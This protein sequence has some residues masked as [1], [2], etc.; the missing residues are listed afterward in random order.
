MEKSVRQD[1]SRPSV[2]DRKLKPA[3]G[4]DSSVS[5]NGVSDA[6]SRDPSPTPPI[7]REIQD[8]GEYVSVKLPEMDISRKVELE[9]EN[10]R[11]RKELAE[12]DAEIR[13]KQDVEK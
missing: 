9:A 5:N 1:I 7:K 13:R 12:K 10:E 2:P 4:L 11:L 8:D 6:K 3:G